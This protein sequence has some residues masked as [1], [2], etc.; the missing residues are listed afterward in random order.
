MH[1]GIAIGPPDLPAALG[2]ATGAAIDEVFA[3]GEDGAA[4]DL[5][6]AGYGEEAH[7]RDLGGGGPWRR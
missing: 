6:P 3:P 1:A 7:E 4:S 5:L 2:A